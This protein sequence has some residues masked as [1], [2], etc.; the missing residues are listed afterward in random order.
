MIYLSRLEE[1]IHSRIR[2]PFFHG[3]YCGPG[4]RGGD[5][6]DEL[7]EACRD[8]DDDYD[9]SQGLDLRER[10]CIQIKAD[11]YFMCRAAR[12]ATNR[13]NRLGLRLKALVAARYFRRRVMMLRALR[14]ALRVFD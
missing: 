12:V 11:L 13:S 7:D 5:P 6:V 4:S 14:S 8:H 1:L 3:N 9:R 2:F 10:L